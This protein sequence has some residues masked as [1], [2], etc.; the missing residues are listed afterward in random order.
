MYIR[1]K[2][3]AKKLWF[4]LENALKKPA[5]YFLKIFFFFQSTI[6]SF[7]LIKENNFIPM[8]AWAGQAV[9]YTID[10]IF[11]LIIDCRQLNF[12]NGFTNIVL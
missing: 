11:K 10:S 9:A 6:L 7:R 2:G 3:S 5:E 1:Y 4:F 8:A 12:T